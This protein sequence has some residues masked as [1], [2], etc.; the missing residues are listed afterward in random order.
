MKREEFFDNAV[1]QLAAALATQGAW[2]AQ[3]DKAVEMAGYLT[4]KLY[5][6]SQPCEEWDAFSD[7]W[8]TTEI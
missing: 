7:N 1:I 4:T 6:E 5:G 3:M 8:N 2:K